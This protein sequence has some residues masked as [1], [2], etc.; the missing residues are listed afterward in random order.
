MV[1][2]QML[3]ASIF[4][5]GWNTGGILAP[6]SD[7]EIPNP[8]WPQAYTVFRQ[9]MISATQRGPHPQWSSLSKSL[10]QAIQEALT[11]T[12]TPA[13]ALATAADKIRPVLAKTPL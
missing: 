10:Q 8:N 11:G 13:Q 5:Q 9:Q 3:D 12:A 4:P 1:I 6:R 2:E 7:I